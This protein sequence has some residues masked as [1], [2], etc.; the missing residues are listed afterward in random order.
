MGLVG[1]VK[2]NDLGRLRKSLVE[3]ECEQGNID[4]ALLVASE[5]GY[6]EIVRCLVQ[7][8]GANVLCTTTDRR[9]W[10]HCKSYHSYP[11]RT[12][13]DLATQNGHSETAAYLNDAMGLLAF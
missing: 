9:A 11:R 4:R 13:L 2:R 3:K 6:T 10:K 5:A 8:G 1:I 12:A 7:E